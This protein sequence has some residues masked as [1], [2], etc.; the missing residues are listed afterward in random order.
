MTSHAA[1]LASRRQ[2]SRI[3][4]EDPH[5]TCDE[6]L[7]TLRG[8]RKCETLFINCCSQDLG[9]G[10][11]YGQVQIRWPASGFEVKDSDSMNDFTLPA[12]KQPVLWSVAFS[13][14]CS[15]PPWHTTL[16]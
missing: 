16:V 15:S 12:P 4:F 13:L 11:H 6:A 1:T 10:G 2:C 3:S 7:T 14:A 5:S 9:L 8:E